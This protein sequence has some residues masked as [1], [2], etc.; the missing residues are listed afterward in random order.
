MRGTI[1]PGTYTI[2]IYSDMEN[3]WKEDQQEIPE[4]IEEASLMDLHLIRTDGN[5][6]PE[7]A[8]QF[9]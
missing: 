5:T 4:K 6:L 3:I 1:D 8:Q 9:S 2:L 7:E